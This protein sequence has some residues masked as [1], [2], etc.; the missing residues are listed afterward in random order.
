MGENVLGGK[1]LM[2]FGEE[3]DAAEEVGTGGIRVFP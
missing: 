2:R 3:D 1:T